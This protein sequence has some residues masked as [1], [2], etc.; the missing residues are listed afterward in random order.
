MDGPQSGGPAYSEEPSIIVTIGKYWGH[1]FLYQLFNTFALIPLMAA[2]LILTLFL[3]IIGLVLG[4]VLVFLVIGWVNKVLSGFI[5]KIDCRGGFMSL[6]GHGFAV[7]LALLLISFPMTFL[8]IFMWYN[9][10]LYYV[11]QYAIIPLVQ[12]FIAKAV[13][14]YFEDDASATAF[15]RGRGGTAAG[16][17]TTCPYCNAV[18]PYRQ[19]DITPEGTAPCR[20]CGAIIQ[21]PRHRLGGPRRTEP[22]G[23]VDPRPSRDDE[24]SVWG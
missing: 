12:G 23:G 9:L 15:P 16:P 5:W 24:D 1:G 11:I 18:F 7:F 20:T 3:S 21:D 19:I 22:A 10:I 4:L 8:G 6:T 14:K 13:A 17:M 2:L